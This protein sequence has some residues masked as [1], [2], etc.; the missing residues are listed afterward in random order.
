M[1][2][3]ARPAFSEHAYHKPPRS[4]QRVGGG[5]VG[6]HPAKGVDPLQGLPR[7]V[8]AVDG[9]PAKYGHPILLE[10]GTAHPLLHRWPQQNVGPGPPA[11]VSATGGR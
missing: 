8:G 10:A 3:P 5:V 2:E 9:E 7:L 4:P 11:R 1:D 6:H